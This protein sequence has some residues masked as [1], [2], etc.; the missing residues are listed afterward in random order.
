MHMK[1]IV[2]QDTLGVN[3]H[4]TTETERNERCVLVLF[5][6]VRLVRLSSGRYATAA[7]IR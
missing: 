2:C 5:L 4:S 1:S 7:T 6:G 3:T